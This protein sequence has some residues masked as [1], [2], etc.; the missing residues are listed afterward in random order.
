MEKA[1]GFKGRAREKTLNGEMT[2]ITVLVWG[3]RKEPS[4]EV[5]MSKVDVGVRPLRGEKFDWKGTRELEFFLF[6]WV[7]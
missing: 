2:F 6:L 7:S 5:R 4:K 3:R 1:G